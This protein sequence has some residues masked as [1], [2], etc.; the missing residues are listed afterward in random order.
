MRISYTTLPVL[1]MLSYVVKACDI[2]MPNIM[3]SVQFAGR[4]VRGTQR[5]VEFMVPLYSDCIYVSQ[6]AP[7]QAGMSCYVSE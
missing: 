4:G 3:M 7:I 6:A 5:S 2:D 1:A